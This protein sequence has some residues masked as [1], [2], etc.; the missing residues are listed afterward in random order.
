MSIQALRERRNAAAIEAR[1][2]MDETKDKAFTD[3]H[4]S[5]YDELTST[6]SD[7]DDRIVREQKL[8]DIEAE[9]KFDNHDF[10]SSRN[11]DAIDPLSERKITDIFLRQGERGFSA[12]QAQKV[13]NT[14]STTTSSE[15]GYTVQ[16]EVAKSIVDSM[17][18]YGG[19]RQVATILQTATGN[20]LSYPTTDG[21]SEVGELVAENGSAAAADP[22]FG[23]VGL[24]VF[25][26]GSKTITVPIELLMDSQVDIE[27]LVR[28]RIQQRIGRITNQHF[29]TGTGTGQPKGVVTAASV[30]KT[31]TTG[32]TLTIIYD[33][34]VDLVE[35]VDQAY[36]DAGNSMFMM[37]QS[38]RK[39]IRKIKDTSG[40]PVWTPGYELGITAK[41]PDLLLGYNIKINNDMAAPAANAK[42]L[43]FGDFSQYIIRDALQVSLFR[44][45][46]SVFTS[47]GQVGFLAWMRCGGNL[48][49]TAAVKVYQHSAT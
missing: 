2:L 34:L 42:T 43:A 38:L 37:P 14:M 29:T 5:R 41:A 49:D 28:K 8:L 22:T 45:T 32:Q 7:I 18:D 15:G 6:I 1:K 44:F 25:K 36:L 17:K 26:Y 46:D 13:F 39:V 24:N 4:R 30:G 48:I 23:T 19:L 11:R 40:R 10:G 16:S 12:E 21:T 20:P 3:D 31:G 9:N 33:D 35:S 27:A 47:K